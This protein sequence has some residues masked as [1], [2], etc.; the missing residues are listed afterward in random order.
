MMNRLFKAI[1]PE[2]AAVLTQKRPFLPYNPEPVISKPP[3]NA[4]LQ[5]IEPLKVFDNVY[6]MGSKAVGVIVID[7]G[8]GFMM[9]DSGSDEREA[10][11]IARSFAEMGLDASKIRLIV[12]SHEHF[13]HYGGLSWFK[14]EVCPDALT[15][16]SRT[17]WNLLQTVPTEFAFTQPR[18][19]N[20]DIF[21]EDG[22]CLKTGNTELL[23]LSTPGHSAGCI[24]FIFNASLH[25]E[26]ISVG[27]MGGSAVW[28][29]FP[30]ARLYE[31][32]IEYFRLYTDLFECNAFA[33][34]HQSEQELDRVR[35]HWSKGTG[36]PWAC[37]KEDFD[38][39]YLQGFRDKVQ[40]TI[41][42]GMMQ[43]YLMPNGKPEG[44]PLPER[45]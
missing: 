40:N 16:M 30:E 5:P 41:Y 15:A 44:S 34:V 11:H 32:S 26:E 24:S 1:T 18:P 36:H 43:E 19:Q 28:P 7:T 21:M 22:L 33:A 6:W 14:K 13:D 10:A 27:V 39:A 42:S 4:P 12:I 35:D 20:I 45:K 17:G 25:G 29:N 2:E 38:R 9:I 37:S 31:N 23:C 8:D 3:K